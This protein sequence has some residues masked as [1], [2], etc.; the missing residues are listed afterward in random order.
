[1]KLLHDRHRPLVALAVLLLTAAPAAANNIITAEQPPI[2]AR[3]WTLQF[4]NRPTYLRSPALVDR[5]GN[6]RPQS[7][8]SRQLLMIVRL[9]TRRMMLRASVPVVSQS[10]NGSGRYG[11]GDAFFE[12]GALVNPG[13]WR[14]RLLGF[15]KAPTGGFDKTQAVNIGGGQWDFG[16]SLYVTRYFD[17]K[18]VDVDLQTQYA[19]R[20]PNTEN[21]VRPGNEL[22]YNLAVAREFQVGV[23]MRLGLEHRA[24][25]GEPNRRDGA[26]VG[27]ARRS[28]AVGPVAMFNLGRFLKGFS[29]WP[30]MI[31]DV[32]NRN[33]SRNQLYYL[34]IQLN[35]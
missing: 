1:M 18:R 6:G 9:Y 25:F 30:T 32:Y 10:Q 20:M 28:L 17:E 29:L 4:D 19:F 27:A 13:P 14:M 31:F 33:C 8:T 16:P 11:L 2:A 3:G 34:K 7:A 26:A 12:G 24:F 15:A 35:Y 22:T 23:P 5:D 21:G